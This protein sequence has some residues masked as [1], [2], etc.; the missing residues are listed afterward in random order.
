MGF[1]TAAEMYTRAPLILQPNSIYCIGSQLEDKTTAAARNQTHGL[2][3]E[4]QVLCSL[5]LLSTAIATQAIPL[6]CYCGFS[7]DRTLH[8]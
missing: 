4:L 3:L 8:T 5:I 1:N 6:Q 7:G 2:L